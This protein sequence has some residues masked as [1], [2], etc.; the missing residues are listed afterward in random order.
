MK[1]AIFSNKTHLS[2]FQSSIQWHEIDRD[3]GNEIFMTLK[4]SNF[5]YFCN[6]PLIFCNCWTFSVK[7]WKFPRFI[8]FSTHII[9][10]MRYFMNIF[11]IFD[12][13]EYFQSNKSFQKNLSS[14]WKVFFRIKFTYVNEL[15]RNELS[16]IFRI[17]KQ[18]DTLYP[19]EL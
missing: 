6:C 15:N 2:W 1:S 17:Q 12:L 10:W 4:W 5:I 11:V 8:T 3:E 13:I 19:E 16:R 18:F 9:S 14:I 7:I